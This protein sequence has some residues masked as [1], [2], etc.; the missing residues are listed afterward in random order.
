MPSLHFIAGSS[1]IAVGTFLIAAGTGTTLPTNV[2]AIVRTASRTYAAQTRGIIGMQRHFTTQVRGGP[3]QHDEQ[4]DSGQLM[5]NG[6]FVSIA[7]YRIARDGR[8]F[9]AGQIAQR[10]EQTNK[11]WTQGKIFFKEP[12][13]PRYL[14][15]YAYGQPQMECASC[16]PRTAAVAFTSLF[17][18]SQHG[19]GTM[20]IDRTKAHIVKLTYTPNVLP[21][22][23]SSGTITEVGGQALPDLWY[24]VRIDEIYHGRAFIF[25]GTGAFTGIFDHFRRFPNR[26]TG[27]AALQSGKI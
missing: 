13:D 25:S 27:E 3:V 5:Q 23:A 11:D 16:P 19:S 15:E 12:Y 18:D 26:A 14:S 9:S 4:S 6:R 2:P 7:Y 24:V 20:Y 1:I 21:P 10:S 8:P 22:H 17:R